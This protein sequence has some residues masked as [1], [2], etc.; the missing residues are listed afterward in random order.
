MNKK[1]LLIL[2]ALSGLFLITNV[3]A[4]ILISGFMANPATNNDAPYEYIQLIATQNINFT[5]SP[6]SV[7]WANNGI[8]NSSGW[9]QG[10]TVTYGFDLTSGN[11]NK[12][13]VFYVGGDGKMIDGAGS[14]SM[15]SEI[16]IRAINTSTT[17]GDGFGT[18]GNTGQMGNGGLSADGLAVF[19]G[20][21][22][23]LTAT[24]IP[25][26]AVFYGTGINNAR[27]ASG[28]Y[29]LPDNDHYNNSGG[30]FGNGT[31]TFIL[32]NPTANNS[33]IKLTGTYLQSVQKW[34]VIRSGSIIALTT[35][36]PVS[37]IATG[38]LFDVPKPS[39][40]LSATKSGASYVTQ[41]STNNILQAFRIEVKDMAAILDT[42]K[43]KLGGSFSQA[44]INHIKLIYSKDAIYQSGD[45]IIKTLNTVNPGIISFDNIAFTLDSAS[46]GY[47]LI[48]VDIS[49]AATTNDSI[50]VDSVYFKDFIF[51]KAKF[52]GVQ[53]LPAGGER[54]I[55]PS[56]SANITTTYLND[57]GTFNVGNIS[58]EQVFTISGSDLSPASGN[59][60]VIPTPGFLVSFTSG[61]G[62]SSTK[63]TRAYTSSSLSPVNVY[64]VFN[65]VAY[66]K[67]S[68]SITIGG[69]GAS[70]I[71]I[72]VSGTGTCGDHTAPVVDT[73]FA[74]SLSRIKVVFS[75]AVSITAETLTN[76]QIMNGIS[77]AKRT[78]SL[79]T[80]Y[81]TLTTPLQT[82]VAA[83]LQVRNIQDTC[84]NHNTMTLVQTFQVKYGQIKIKDYNIKEVT[85]INATTGQADSVNIYCRLKGVIQSINFSQNA[86]N[87]TFYIHDNTDGIVVNRTGAIPVFNVRR[88]DKIRVIGRIQQ[89]NGLTRITADSIVVVDS[90]QQLRTPVVSAKLNE[91]TESEVIRINN[92]RLINA[93]LWPVNAG[94][95][96]NVTATN[97]KDTFTITIFTRC[98]IQ[99][100]PAPTSLFDIIGLGSQN[101]NSMPYTA[102][103]TI[104]PRDLN[105]LIIHPPY[106]TY[107]IA[108]VHGEN[109]ITGI[110]D[111]IGIY[112]KLIGVV[113]GINDGT[114]G[115]SFTIID[116]TGGINVFNSVNTNPP[117]T[118]TEGDEVAV[119]GTI[120]QYFGLTEIYPDTIKV[121]TSGQTLMSPVVVYVLDESTES[122][123]LQ[124]KNL[125]IV[126]PSQW[127]V[128]TLNNIVDVEVTDGA[129]NYMVRINKNCDIQG[130]PVPIGNFDVTGI[131]SQYD[132][133]APYTN[134]YYI[135]PRYKT[136]IEKSNGIK[137][138]VILN[139]VSLF[140]NPSYGS[141]LIQNG[142]RNKLIIEVFNPIGQ[143]VYKTSSAFTFQQIDLPGSK[144]LY[145]VKVTDV[146]SLESKTM[147]IELK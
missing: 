92:L 126:P 53:P 129:H 4:Q 100:T 37:T 123:L 98:N 121:I 136:D 41:G 99:G 23:F 89:T 50:Y 143:E 6:Y 49:S 118:V 84:I 9:V 147:K 117:Y 77:T 91:N 45:S 31:N 60:M 16:W 85:S 137:E 59:I 138:S 132:P 66:N 139:M 101:D 10:G 15:S 105:D 51:R 87:S 86:N 90:F 74:V 7:V 57:F 119:I 93:A 11:V 48:A 40:Y 56:G 36:S 125:T 115:L 62:Y 79:D 83:T 58:P 61:S 35:A 109:P 144:G 8:A 28:G 73:A 54:T 27:P 103:Y 47:L 44:D 65:P 142:T 12:G 30:T 29:T 14:T 112:C 145:M 113:H 1:L 19:T 116:K 5:T 63:I 68:S 25:I 104:W 128:S 39:I 80:V 72:P 42:M 43:I 78:T 70:P 75:E 106:P 3:K 130:T 135:I 33:Y 141:F 52:Y 88:G 76:Y 134:N 18:N 20:T 64:V 55:I 81:L 71:F 32:P 46:I 67:V 26:D 21:T 2:L 107:T 124:I 82:A 122:K 102:G 22:Q 13:D 38:I 111:S 140:P 24:S 110:A 133:T 114:T 127:P 95:S 69:G 131:G 120:Q 94:P 146:T 97:G 96:R 108:E 34:D 17:T